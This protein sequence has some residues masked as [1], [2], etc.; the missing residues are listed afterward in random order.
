MYF[1]CVLSMLLIWNQM[2]GRICYNFSELAPPCLALDFQLNDMVT[3]I[4]CLGFQ[5]KLYGGSYILSCLCFSC[6]QTFLVRV[7]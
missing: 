6:N 5:L 3:A 4:F 7:H 1:L 2:N